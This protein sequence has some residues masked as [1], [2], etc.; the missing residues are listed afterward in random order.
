[1]VVICNNVININMGLLLAACLVE[2]KS[3]LNGSNMPHHFPVPSSVSFLD[4]FLPLAGEAGFSSVGVTIV[5]LLV[6]ELLPK[7]LA[8]KFPES[9]LKISTY[10]MLPLQ[11]ARLPGIFADGLEYPIDFAVGKK[12]K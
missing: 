3:F 11:L 7:A 9:F 2:S 4:K 6:A 12:T 8:W 1:M 10:V 5:L